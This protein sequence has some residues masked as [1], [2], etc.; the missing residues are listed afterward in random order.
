MPSAAI[1]LALRLAQARELADSGRPDEAERLLAP[2]P[3]ALPDDPL[4]LHAL[5]VIVTRRGDYPRARRLWQHLARA[6]PGHPEAAAMLD[7]IDTW[8]TRPAWMR[9]T[10]PLVLVAAPA[11]LLLLVAWLAFAP[12]RRAPALARPTPA[13]PVPYAA[14]PPAAPVR[15]LS[16]APPPA[17]APPP[18]PAEEEPAPAVTF[19]VKPTKKR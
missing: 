9:F 13:A 10:P 7:A 2:S 4:A 14:T 12:S 15:P 6:Q 16:V 8:T 1:P 5:A 11:A 17:A 3:A 18:A 19:Q